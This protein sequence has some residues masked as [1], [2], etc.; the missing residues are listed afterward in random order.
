LIL[1]LRNYLD[2]QTP[3]FVPGAQCSQKVFFAL[4]RNRASVAANLSH[5]AAAALQLPRWTTNQN[6]SGGPETAVAQNLSKMRN[7]GRG[8]QGS[9]RKGDSLM[10]RSTFVVMAVV[11]GL[12]VPAPAYARNPPANVS[13]RDSCF[14]DSSSRFSDSSSPRQRIVACTALIG[15]KSLGARRKASALLSR[16]NAQGQKGEYGRVI[17]DTTRAIKRAPSAVAYYTRALAYH[18]LGQNE[19][20]VADCDAALEIE[21]DNPNALFVRAASYQGM[22]E[23]AKAIRDYTEVLRLDPA[24]EDALFSRGAAYYSAGE[25]E[26]AVDDFSS[27]IDRGVAD[28]TVLYLRALAYEELGRIADARSDMEKA[29]RLDPDLQGSTIPGA[30]VT[31]GQH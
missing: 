14:S 8:S 7:G 13:A 10:R 17:E 20:A 9:R 23:Y 16:A 19:R 29:L 6:Q 3:R 2:Q 28:G 5:Q 11:A 31:S 22:A 24:R 27:T 25:Y 21:S 12:G 1:I 4:Q 30:P 15:A 26:Q 18:N